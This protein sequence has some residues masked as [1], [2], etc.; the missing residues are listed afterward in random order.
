MTEP[1]PAAATRAR[2]VPR[3][4]GSTLIAL[5]ILAVLLFP[6]YWM[7]N[8]SFFTSAQVLSVDPPLMPWS[9]TLDGYRQALESQGPNLLTSIAVA[10]GTV[11]LTLAIAIPAGYALARFRVPGAGIVLFAIMVVQMVPNI[12]LA[13]SLF[14]ILSSIGLFDTYVALVLADSTLAIP[15]A[16]IVLRAFMLGIPGEVIESAQLDGA[17]Y[18]RTLTRV[19]AP[20]SRNAIITAGL[21]TFLFAWGDFLFGV[22]LTSGQGLVPVTVGIYQFIGTQVS[23]WNAILATAVL[24]SIPAAI[25][26][27]VAQRYIAAGVT[28]GAM[29]E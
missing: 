25:L 8:A 12:V 1:R 11:V 4:L 9:G 5:V 16:I 24:A 19:V 23:E 10:T 28:G 15:F 26:L 2:R 21:F 17:G 29:K 13:N 27:V 18:L 20:M 7:V 14:D 22:T 3:R 6:V